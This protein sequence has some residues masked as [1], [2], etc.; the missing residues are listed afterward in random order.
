[1]AFLA[2][3]GERSCWRVEATGDG[4]LLSAAARC[5]DNLA[6]LRGEKGSQLSLYP[7]RGAGGVRMLAPGGGV[8]VPADSQADVDAIVARTGRPQFFF[9]L[10]EGQEQQCSC[11]RVRRL[12]LSGAIKC[13]NA[14]VSG[15]TKPVLGR[16][17]RS[18]IERG[19][20]KSWSDGEAMAERWR[21]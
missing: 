1:M 17:N 13:S 12:D 9:L 6:D 3:R 4:V 10:V 8:L 20:R 14:G 5:D 19:N 21:I 16:S 15:A 7:R 2:V 11:R 18:G